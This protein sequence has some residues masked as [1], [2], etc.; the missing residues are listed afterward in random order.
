M[1]TYSLYHPSQWALSWQHRPVIGR[2][3]SPPEP[4]ASSQDS[5]PKLEGSFRRLQNGTS[6]TPYRRP[7]PLS[8]MLSSLARHYHYCCHGLCDMCT[9]RTHARTHNRLV[10]FETQSNVTAAVVPLHSHSPQQPRPCSPRL[11]GCAREDL[12][13]ES[14]FLSASSTALPGPRTDGQ[15]GSGGWQARHQHQCSPSR[16]RPRMERR[17]GW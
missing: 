6:G 1:K 5:E 17:K 2:P 3:R 14:G 7:M 15:S 16:T 4:M 10:L 13:T 8:H 12:W 9:A 11:V